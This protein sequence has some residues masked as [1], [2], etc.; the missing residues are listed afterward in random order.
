M[1]V[2]SGWIDDI[3]GNAEVLHAGAEGLSSAYGQL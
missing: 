3:P 2:F 1:G